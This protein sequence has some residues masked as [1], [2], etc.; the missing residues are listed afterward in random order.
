MYDDE[1]LRSTTNLVE[2][3]SHGENY[4]AELLLGTVKKSICLSQRLRLVRTATQV[5]GMSELQAQDVDI[6]YILQAS[7]MKAATSLDSSGPLYSI[8]H[9]FHI[10][11]PQHC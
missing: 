4:R 6:V 11:G 9:I 3:D 10:T 8:H 2:L 5:I 7:S 1:G